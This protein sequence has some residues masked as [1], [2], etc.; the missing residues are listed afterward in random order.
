METTLTHFH[1]RE[2]P[3]GDQDNWGI[4]AFWTRLIQF[5]HMLI[6]FLKLLFIIY[7][8]FAIEIHLLIPGKSGDPTIFTKSW[9]KLK[10][11]GK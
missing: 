8:I 1:R 6:A 5:K 3:L 7:I 9:V 11:L 4:L 10:P 2:R